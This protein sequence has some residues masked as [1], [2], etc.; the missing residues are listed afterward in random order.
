MARKNGQIIRLGPSTWL[1]RIYV[2]R[3]SRLG[4]AHTLARPFKGACAPRRLTSIAYSPR[5]TSDA[6]S[7]LRSKPSTSISTIVSTS[8]RGYLAHC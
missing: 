8:V 6:T 3:D 1:V 4:A 2:D 5:Q 7:A